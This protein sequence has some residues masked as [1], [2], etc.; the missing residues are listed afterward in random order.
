MINRRRPSVS[1]DHVNCT[2]ALPTIKSKAFPYR[3][4]SNASENDFFD[5]PDEP[6]VAMFKRQFRRFRTW[7]ILALFVM[8]M[9]WRR[10]EKPPSLLPHLRY[11]EVD[12]SRYAYT[13][14]AT[15][16]TYLCNAVMVFEA[17]QRLGSRA[18]RVLFYPVEWDLVVENDFD[19]ISQLLVMAR[20]DYHVQLR[21]VVIEGIK[22]D[23]EGARIGMLRVIDQC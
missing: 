12:W 22:M 21:P 16:E 13:T 14:Y 4:G 3:R 8:F 2:M 23:G 9:M 15:S 19:R 7:V 17:L 18:E 6:L 20:N 11:D 5:I 10:R 1:V